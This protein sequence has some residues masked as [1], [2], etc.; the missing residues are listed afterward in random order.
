MKDELPSGQCHPSTAL[1]TPRVGPCAWLI[2][3]IKA[4]RELQLW[5][6][7]LPLSYTP[8]R[9]TDEE[10]WRGGHVSPC[11]DRHVV[12]ECPLTTFLLTPSHLL[13]SNSDHGLLV[14]REFSLLLKRT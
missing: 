6:Y 11:S 14:G 7:P 13:A 1:E 2:E 5:L 8:N 3:K 12:I 10:P 9:L 4:V